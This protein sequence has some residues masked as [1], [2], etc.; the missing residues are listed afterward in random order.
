MSY[1]AFSNASINTTTMDTRASAAHTYD[2]IFEGL[3]PN[4]KHKMFLDDVDY[5]WACRG[6]GQN[7]GEEITSDNTGMARVF[8][9]YEI[10]FQQPASYEMKIPSSLGGSGNRIN[11]QNGRFEDSVMTYYKTFEI[12][13]AD[14]LSHAII[15]LPFPIVLINTDYNTIEQHD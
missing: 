15:H 4:T 9:L 7:L 3:R 14:G 5:T 13:S 11:N 10:P 8:V 1:N 12:K 6:W 2:W